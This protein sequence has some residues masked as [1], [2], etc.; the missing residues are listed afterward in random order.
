MHAPAYSRVIITRLVVEAFQYLGVLLHVHYEVVGRVKH[1][2]D[3]AQRQPAHHQ[4]H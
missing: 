2:Y 4:I 1:G 3:Q